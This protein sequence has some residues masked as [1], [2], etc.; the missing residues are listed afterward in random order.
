[1]TQEERNIILSKGKCRQQAGVSE[2]Q[3]STEANGKG[4]LQSAMHKLIT[5][6]AFDVLV[7]PT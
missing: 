5:R 1:M 4:V 7:L 3:A 6:K 2:P